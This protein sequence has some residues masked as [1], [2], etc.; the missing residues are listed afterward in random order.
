MK[1]VDVS[2][3]GAVYSM[4]VDFDAM[5]QIAEKVGDPFEIA[6]GMTRGKQL[7][8]LQMVETIAIGVRLAGCAL[9]RKEIGKAIVAAGAQDYLKTASTYIIS[10]VSG[11]PAVPTATGKKKAK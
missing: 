5:E 2:I 9:E 8:A 7:T 1:V 11:G 10:I 4:P 3:A 6:L